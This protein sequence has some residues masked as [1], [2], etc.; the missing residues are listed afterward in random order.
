MLSWHPGVLSWQPRACSALAEMECLV[1][2]CDIF[3][4]FW[5]GCQCL[6]TLGGRP[7]RCA[8]YEVGMTTPE[9]SDSM[10]ALCTFDSPTPCVPRPPT[11]TPTPMHRCRPISHLVCPHPPPPTHPH[12][13]HPTPPPDA[14]PQATEPPRRLYQQPVTAAGAEA[15]RFAAMVLSPRPSAAAAG[16]GGEGR[17]GQAPKVGACRC[18]SRPCCRRP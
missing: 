3:S 13:P 14:P 4:F 8:P 16:L 2:L 5:E 18:R 17:D 1:H 9:P 10:C 6:L 15:A 11:P 12:P 7:W